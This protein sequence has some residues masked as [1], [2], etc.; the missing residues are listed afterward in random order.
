MEIG[1][2]FFDSVIS[3]LLKMGVKFIRK[4]TLR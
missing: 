2:T 4:D 3:S 1:L